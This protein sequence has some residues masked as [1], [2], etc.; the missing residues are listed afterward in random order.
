MMEECFHVEYNFFIVYETNNIHLDI[1][2]LKQENKFKFELY[3]SIHEDRN[4]IPIQIPFCIFKTF[5]FK[6]VEFGST[7]QI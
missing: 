2:D 5:N 1:G 3:K 6:Q 4:I 7:I